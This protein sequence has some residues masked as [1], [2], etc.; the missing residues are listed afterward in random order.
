VLLEPDRADAELHR[1][2][3]FGYGQRRR[4]AEHAYQ[5]TRA[6]LRERTPELAAIFARH[7]IRLRLD[8]LDDPRRTLVAP[9][10][11]RRLAHALARLHTVL[12]DLET[13]LQPA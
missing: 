8:V 1:A 9:P 6:W 10:Q 12:D 4:L 13:E 3:I 7:G 5:R 11:P 2:N